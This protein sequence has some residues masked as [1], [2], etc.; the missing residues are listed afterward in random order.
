MS[1]HFYLQ[2]GYTPAGAMWAACGLSVAFVWPT[3]VSFRNPKYV[4]MDFCP[5]KGTT[6]LLKKTLQQ[7]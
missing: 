1:K 7:A 4:L 2:Q 3:S 6:Q 5:F